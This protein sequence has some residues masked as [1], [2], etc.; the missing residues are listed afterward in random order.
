GRVNHLTFSKN[1][2]YAVTFK[3]FINFITQ[4]MDQHWVPIHT[5]CAPCYNRYDF[6]LDLATFKDDLRYIY[7]QAGIAESHEDTTKNNST[8][9][10]GPKLQVWDYFKELPRRL[11]KRVHAI[12]RMDFK[13][14]G[15]EI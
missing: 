2:S 4:R 11:L 9:K 13:L 3:Q 8:R 5:W 10:A 7:K 15:Y 6:F 12:Y 14:F 1:N